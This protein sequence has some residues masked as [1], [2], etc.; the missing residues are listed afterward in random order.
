MDDIS[1]KILKEMR[2]KREMTLREILRILPSKYNDHRDVYAFAD[3]ITD[4]YIDSV[5][6]HDGKD[7]RHSNNKDLAI[8]L[9]T[10]SFGKGEFEY[11]GQK[12]INGGDFNNQLFFCTAKTVLYLEE[13]RQRRADRLWAFIIGITVGIVVAII[14]SI[15]TKVFGT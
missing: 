11:K 13:E 5:M 1:H 12:L 3:L 8:T 9:Y 10:A 6:K 4:G 14:S 7:I 15:I 2:E